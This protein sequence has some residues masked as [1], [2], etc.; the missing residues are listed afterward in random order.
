MAT[1]M[2]KH[3]TE[4]ATMFNCNPS[5]LN[6]EKNDGPTCKPTANTNSTSPKSFIKSSRVLS[7]DNPKC[8]QARP[9]NNTKAMPSEIPNILILPRLIP[10]AI[11][12]AKMKMVWAMPSL[13]KSERNQFIA[14]WL[15]HWYPQ[16]FLFASK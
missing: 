13:N 3:T 10:N 7:T 1:I 14:L 2:S 15:V 11:T 9:T 16:N 8:P 6:E 5:F 12:N 4:T